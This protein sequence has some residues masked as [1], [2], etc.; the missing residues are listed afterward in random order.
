MSTISLCASVDGYVLDNTDCNDN[1]PLIF[2]GA[3]E[4]ENGSDDNC[5]G[6]IDEGFPDNPINPANNENNVG[7]GGGGCFISSIQLSAAGSN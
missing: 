1:D 2:P 5:D 7:G 3:T 6:R 4:I